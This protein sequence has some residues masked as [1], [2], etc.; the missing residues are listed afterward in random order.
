MLL[1][2][3]C[4]TTLDLLT[5]D[6]ISLSNIWSAPNV[7]A[8]SARPTRG[9]NEAPPNVGTVDDAREPLSTPSVGD[10]EE[11]ALSK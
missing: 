3:H 1:S 7:H 2:P 4:Y 10:L 5:Y 6:Y 8:H 11:K 9:I